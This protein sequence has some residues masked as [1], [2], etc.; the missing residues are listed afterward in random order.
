MN[1]KLPKEIT[2]LTAQI[3]DLE[4]RIETARADID[5]AGAAA[6]DAERLE[7][8]LSAL[9]DKRA[10]VKAEAFIAGTKADIAELDR[11]EAELEKASRRAR[12]DGKAG[13]LA[14][15]LLEEKIAEHEAEIARLEEDRKS[16]AV[17]WLTAQREKA[18]DQ[19]L[20]ALSALGPIVADALAA[21][22]ARR[23]LGAGVFRGG[24]DPFKRAQHGSHAL[25]LLSGRRTFE[26][27]PGNNGRW[28]P[29]PIVWVDDQEHGK[30]ERDQLIAEITAAG[31]L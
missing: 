7:G 16:K 20:D 8:E 21:E 19:W 14:V 17:E 12:E 30:R 6:R 25:R 1:A 11:Q 15:Q 10:R 24:D 26:E 31:V 18:V 9:S 27:A 4:A 29:P 23:A 3:H 2:A 22:A 28:S 5:R 13:A